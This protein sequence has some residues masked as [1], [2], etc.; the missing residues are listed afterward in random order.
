MVY[1]LEMVIF[2]SYVSH[3]QMVKGEGHFGVL[4]VQHSTTKPAEVLPFAYCFD[5]PR[6]WHVESTEGHANHGLSLSRVADGVND[7]FFQG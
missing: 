7:V 1:L 6:Y 4:R 3:N 5:D 2:H